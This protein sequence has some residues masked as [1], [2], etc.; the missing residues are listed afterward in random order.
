MRI[1]AIM[2]ALAVAVGLFAVIASGSSG[3]SSSS[4][5]SGVPQGATVHASGAPSSASAGAADVVISGCEIDD[6]LESP[7]AHLTIT[8]HS[9]KSSNYLVTIA[10]DSK[11]GKTQIDTGIAS[12]DNLLPGQATQVDANSLK[13][14]VAPGF[15]CKVADV[16]RLAA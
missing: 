8:N 12:A 13:S 15:V 16:V 5:G 14:N 7:V 2:T 10:F 6:T 1:K 9:S 4:R 3:D 11:D